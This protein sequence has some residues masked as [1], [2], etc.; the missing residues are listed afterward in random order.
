MTQAFNLS[1]LANNLNTSGQLDATDGLVNAVPVTNGGTGASTATA[2]RTNL[3][4]AI[5]T[6]VP[7]PTGTGASGTWPIAI[8]GNAT[9]V[10]DGVYT[11]GNQTIGGTKTFTNGI[12]FNDA[13]VQTTA[14]SLVPSSISAIG[15]VVMVANASTSNLVP[16]STIAGSSLYYPS[17]ISQVTGGFVY[18]EGTTIAPVTVLRPPGL[19]NLALMQVAQ[20]TTV[21]NTGYTT[22]GGHT[23]L[24]GTWRILSIGVARSS[25]YDATY[26][27][28]T[29]TSY[30]LFAQRIS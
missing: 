29:A 28:T 3:G 30:Y 25:A 7:S 15:S 22:P 17:T 26:N 10:T 27:F 23:A 5:G 4:V 19:S 14:A 12:T 6:D 9:T 11:T 1:Q 21:G 16:S 2:A 24:S 18:T 20:R 8:S 13:T